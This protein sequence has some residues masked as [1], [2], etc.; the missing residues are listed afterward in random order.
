MLKHIYI[1]IEAQHNRYRSVKKNI[2]P[3]IITATT[4]ITFLIISTSFSLPVKNLETRYSSH[5]NTDNNKT[6]VADYEKDT[7]YDLDII[8]D[9]I[10]HLD[11]Y[12]NTVYN[13]IDDNKPDNIGLRNSI[14]FLENK[15]KEINVIQEKYKFKELTDLKLLISNNIRQYKTYKDQL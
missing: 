7:D 15:L 8:L 4:I 12:I 6:T 5:N 11:K 2:L 3:I 14:R 1:D 13:K 9:S 10:E